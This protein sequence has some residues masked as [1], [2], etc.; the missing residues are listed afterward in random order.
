MYRSEGYSVANL[1]EVYAVITNACIRKP[2][3]VI[4]LFEKE[5]NKIKS[6]AMQQMKLKDFYCIP[7][8]SN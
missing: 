6:D 2:F 3:N 7:F 5:K 8:L 1:T 4:T